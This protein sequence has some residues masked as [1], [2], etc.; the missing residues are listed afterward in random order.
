MNDL[1]ATR[2]QDLLSLRELVSRYGDIIDDR[3]WA[4]LR[5]V[6]TPDATLDLTDLG[7]GEINGI[8]NI[9]EYMDGP[10]I[11]PVAH[12]MS[13]IHVPQLHERAGELRCRLLAVQDDGSVFVGRYRDQVVLTEDGWRISRRTFSYTRR[14][15]KGRADSGGRE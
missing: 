7:V 10:A 5:E 15:Q 3:Q 8:E 6:F 9:I 4:Q 1:A 12:L 11:H 13:N 14:A 2:Y